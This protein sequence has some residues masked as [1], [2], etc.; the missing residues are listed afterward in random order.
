[1]GLKPNQAARELVASIDLPFPP[2][3]WAFECR[4]NGE[5]RAQCNQNLAAL[6]AEVV[7][8]VKNLHE[9]YK[10]QAAKYLLQDKMLVQYEKQL[11][12]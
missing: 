1:M 6:R 12:A 4:A 8:H 11:G 2:E 9:H 7:G 3:N 10:A 5:D